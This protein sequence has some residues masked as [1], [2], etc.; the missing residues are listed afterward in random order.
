VVFG[1]SCRLSAQRLKHQGI[2]FKQIP[3]DIRSI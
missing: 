2:V 1:E 3:Y